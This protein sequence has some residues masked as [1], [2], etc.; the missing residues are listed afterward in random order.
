[1]EVAREDQ[2]VVVRVRDTGPGIEEAHLDRVFDRF[3]KIDK[4]RGRSEAGSGLGLAIV[5][6]LVEA[7]GGQVG[8]ESS[9]GKGSTF[10]FTLP[11]A[12][13]SDSEY[14]DKTPSA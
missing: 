3:Y 7:Q 12:E 2:D 11:R 10:Y 14:H 13:R 5:R 9:P 8:V 6:Q 1:M 4:S